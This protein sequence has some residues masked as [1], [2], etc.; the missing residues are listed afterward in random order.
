M[1][2]PPLSP[3]TSKEIV[4]KSY[5]YSRKP[6]KSTKPPIFLGRVKEYRE[7]IFPGMPYHCELFQQGIDPF[8]KHGNRSNEIC[9]DQRRDST[10]NEIVKRRHYELSTDSS[11]EMG[12]SWTGSRIR[13]QD[14]ASSVL[15]KPNKTS[16]CPNA[17]PF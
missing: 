2:K 1:R 9:L 3:A 5:E 15:N 16:L 17:L 14:R 13:F 7:T 10:K 8:Y 4:I 6:T 11:E 12:T